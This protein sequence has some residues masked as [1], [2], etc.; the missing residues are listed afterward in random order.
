MI[1]H[2]ATGWHIKTH[3][4]VTFQASDLELRRYPLPMV[5][6]GEIG[7]RM[8]YLSLDPAYRVWASGRNM[9][10]LP[11]QPVGAL[12]PGSGIGVVEDR[13]IQTIHQARSLLA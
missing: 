2:T 12:L 9:V 1:A 13:N 8:Q 5:R 4:G 7:I 11:P 6:P 10:Y 3:P